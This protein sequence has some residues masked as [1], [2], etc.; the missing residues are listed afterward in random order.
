MRKY[1]SAETFKASC[2]WEHGSKAFQR[3]SVFSPTVFAINHREG[4]IQIYEEKGKEKVYQQAKQTLLFF[5]ENFCSPQ[6]GKSI[7][8]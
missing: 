7:S 3:V 1:F 5:K 6:L 2:L 8:Y 4:G